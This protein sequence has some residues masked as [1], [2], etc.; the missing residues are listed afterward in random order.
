MRI[1]ASVILVFLSACGQNGTSSANDPADSRMFRGG[2]EHL[3]T[4]VSPGPG[5]FGGVAWRFATGGPVRSTPALVDGIL[6]VGGTDGRMYAISADLGTLE[7]A[8]DV[9]SSVV[10]SPAVAAGHVV[11]IDRSNVIHALDRN[12]GEEEWRRETGPD[13]PLPWGWEGWDYI[14]PSATVIADPRSADAELVIIGSGAGGVY[15]LDAGTGSER[16]RFEVGAR[17]RSTPA[18]SDGTV[19]IG[20]SDGVLYALDLGTGQE[21]WRFETSGVSMNAADFGFDRTQIYSSPTV[22]GGYVYF[23]SRDAS[24]YALDAASGTMAWHREDGSAWVIGSPAF[25]NDRLFVGRSS[26]GAFRARDAATGDELWVQSTGAWIL[27]SPMVSGD[28]VYIGNRDGWVFAFAAEDGRELWKYRTTGSVFSSPVVHGDRLY[29]GSDDGFV[30]A[31]RG[32]AIKPR[33]AVFWDDSLMAFSAW[34][35]SESHRP[36]ADYFS[37]RGYEALDAG[38]LEDFLATRIRDQIPSVVVFAMDA[39]PAG[40]AGAASDTTLLRRYLDAGGKVVWLGFPPLL[41]ARDAGGSFQG[42]DRSRPGSL[43]GVD[44]GPWNDDVYG[45]TPTDE[46]RAWGLDRWMLSSP[47]ATAESVD[48][49][50]AVDEMGVPAAW[51]KEYGGPPGTGFVTVQPNTRPERLEAIRRVAEY[52]ILTRAS[53]ADSQESRNDES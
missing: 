43:L 52:G 9:G 49:I 22:A 20:A 13:L 53:S 42:I 24:L 28:V 15:A 6:Y 45:A 40:V 48:V 35:G 31:F 50:L 21:K 26:S 33:T 5:A 3:G 47:T 46:G 41:V 27:G 8:F 1:I 23:G 17:V 4:A 16:W 36:V 11:F 44:M 51:V 14:G 2:P 12:T 10:S 29:V 32:G 38:A 19:Y 34:G 7:W 25:Q 30:Y 39:V 18:V 37:D